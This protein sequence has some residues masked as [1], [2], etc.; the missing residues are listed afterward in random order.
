M[1]QPS[2]GVRRKILWEMDSWFTKKIH[3]GILCLIPI[4]K[5]LFEYHIEAE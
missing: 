4:P 5:C 2:S 3:E 1:A